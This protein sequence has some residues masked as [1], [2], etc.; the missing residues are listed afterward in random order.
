MSYHTVA[1]QHAHLPHIILSSALVKFYPEGF[2]SNVLIPLVSIL[3][4]GRDILNYYSVLAVSGFEQHVEAVK[5]KNIFDTKLFFDSKEDKNKL[6]LSPNSH[7]ATE[8]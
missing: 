2:P 3:Y 1:K 7:L 6:Q 5:W 8:D 4:K